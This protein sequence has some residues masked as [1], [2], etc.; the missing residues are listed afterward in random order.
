MGPR[1]ITPAQIERLE[2]GEGITFKMRDDDK[3]LVYTGKIIGDFDGFEPLDD[4][5]MYPIVPLLLHTT[6]TTPYPVRQ[7]FR[8]LHIPFALRVQTTYPSERK[9]RGRGEH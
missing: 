9:R 5:G 8:R 1:S 6:T 2:R 7:D 3:E 4:F